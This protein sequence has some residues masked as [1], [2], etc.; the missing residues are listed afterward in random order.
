MAPPLSLLLHALLETILV[1][2][3]TA[4][5][6]QPGDAHFK[7]GV[8]GGGNCGDLDEGGLSSV[9]WWYDW[10]H[11]AKGFAECNGTSPKHAEYVPMIWGKW[12]KWQQ[13][14]ADIRA[15]APDARFLFSYNEPDHS[16]SS[17]LK[18]S[19]G[20]S[21]WENMERLAWALNVTLVGPCVSNYNSGE[22]WLSTFSAAFHNLTGRQPRMDHMCLHAYGTPQFLE[23]S[24]G[25]MAKDYKRPIWVNEFACPPYKGCTAPHQLSMMKDTL[26][27]LENSPYVFRYA[28]FD[29]RDNRPLPKGADSLHVPNSSRLTPLGEYYNTFMPT[30]PNPP[31]VPPA[32]RPPA[33]PPAP[34]GP[35]PPADCPG[36]NLTACEKLCPTSPAPVHADCVQQCATRCT[37]PAPPP[38]PAPPPPAP[39]PTPT[40]P[41]PTPTPP[42]TNCSVAGRVPLG[43][44]KFCYEICN[45]KCYKGECE[46]H[47]TVL[48]DGQSIPC[49]FHPPAAAGQKA[50]CAPDT[51]CEK[52]D[53]DADADAARK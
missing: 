52:P 4:Q 26:A 41:T 8:G 21:R 3:A 28:W 48:K 34:P 33:P 10:G 2:V 25:R 20:A 22:W 47:Y 53:A 17:Y 11:T 13:Q 5:R 36:G 46:H 23:G 12:G 39:T 40:P 9:S 30:K 42:G 15:S 18:P 14:E 50:K 49:L 19:D 32:P 1:V 43:K 45:T 6:L 31:P 38:T 35:S 29:N 51:A 27:W 16:G 24:V 37:G 44:G 7:K